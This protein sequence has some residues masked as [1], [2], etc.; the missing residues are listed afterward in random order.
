MVCMPTP[1][2]SLD[3]TKA[4]T[5]K[6]ADARAPQ[7]DVQ[8]FCANNAAIIGDARIGWQTSRLLELEAQ[9]RRRIVELDAKKAE[10]VAWLRK[11]DDALKQ[12]TESIVAIYA[13]MRP[14]AAALQ[15]A[16]MD[17]AM[18]AAIL[19]KL[20]SRVA[21]ALLNEMEAGRA[22]RLTRLMAGPDAAPDGKKS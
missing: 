10:Y 12:A 21:G 14:E 1:S 20:S 16:A 13:R 2:F 8:Q 7:T 11:R 4:A 9:I 5:A 6:P 18:A 15:L 22:A 3:E 17:D 19:T